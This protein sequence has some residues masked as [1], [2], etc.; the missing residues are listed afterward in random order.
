MAACTSTPWGIPNTRRRKRSTPWDA[1]RY[2]LAGDLLVTALARELDSDRRTFALE[3][4]VAYA[5]AVTIWPE[6]GDVPSSGRVQVRVG[7]TTVFRLTAR[8]SSGVVRSASVE[9]IRV[10]ES[11]VVPP[12]PRTVLMA[13]GLQD[14]GLPPRGGPGRGYNR[15]SRR[16]DLLG[17][18]RLGGQS[19]AADS[20]AA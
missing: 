18:S 1:V 17:P 11:L 6:I 5:A 8:S 4:D 14:R 10:G 3:W 12:G 16:Q 13:S 20:T 7:G 15:S 2:S 9:V 19:G